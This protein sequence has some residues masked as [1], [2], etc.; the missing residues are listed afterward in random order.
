MAVTR[1][2]PLANRVSRIILALTAATSLCVVI[3]AA[4][5]ASASKSN[6]SALAASPKATEIETVTAM[7]PLGRG[8]AIRDGRAYDVEDEDCTRAVVS[9][10]DKNGRIRVMNNVACAN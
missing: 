10:A 1:E 7:R 3:A 6:A 2:N 8:P 9:T 5:S 4:P